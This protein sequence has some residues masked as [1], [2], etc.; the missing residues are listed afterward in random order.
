MTGEE[1]V[2]VP[3]MATQE[4]N[5]RLARSADWQCMRTLFGVLYVYGNPATNIFDKPLGTLSLGEIFRAV[6]FIGAAIF[7]LKALFNP[8]EDSAIRDAWTVIGAILIF[9]IGALVVYFY[10]TH[11]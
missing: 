3:E 6:F 4:P 9:G 11:R 5:A 7:L 8:S 10:A 2:S 1:R